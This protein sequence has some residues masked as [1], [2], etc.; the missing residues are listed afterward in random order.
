MHFH[1]AARSQAGEGAGGRGRGRG[2]AHRNRPAAA[3]RPPGDGVNGPLRVNPTWSPT[4]SRPS[5]DQAWGR[6][7]PHSG[8]PLPAWRAQCLRGAFTIGHLEWPLPCFCLKTVVTPRVTAPACPARTPGAHRRSP[9]LNW[10]VGRGTGRGGGGG[11]RQ[12]WVP[13]SQQTDPA[14]SLLWGVGPPGP[15]R[16]PWA[17]ACKVLGAGR[18]PLWGGGRQGLGA[19]GQR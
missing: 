4:Q 11:W 8:P 5:K 15:C 6:G 14:C 18:R 19:G 3:P 13:Q 10:G 12:M 2:G 17:C 1:S 9:E 7:C 16:T